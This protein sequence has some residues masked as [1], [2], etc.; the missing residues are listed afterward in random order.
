MIIENAWIDMSSSRSYREELV[1]EERSR[2]WLGGNPTDA[3]AAQNVETLPQ[4][5]S[6][7]ISAAAEEAQKKR[8]HFQLS[9]EDKCKISL[10]KSLLEAFT[11]KEIKF[12]LPLDW[13]DEMQNRLEAISRPVSNS[14][15]LSTPNWGWEYDFYSSYQESEQTTF[16]ASAV[17]KTADGREIN[18]SVSLNLSRSFSSQ[19]ELHIRAGNAQ[20][21]DPLV[22]NFDGSAAALGERS[23]EFDLDCDGELDL[24]SFLKPGSGF[25]A[26][27]LN[28][29]GTIN[30]GSELFGVSNGDGFAHLAQYDE[31]G[32]GWIDENDSVFDRLQIWTKDSNGNDV[33]FA[34][35]QKGIGAIC[36][37]N[38]ATSFAMKNSANELDGQLRSSGIF[39]R[40]NGTAGTI[41]Q[42]DLRV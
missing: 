38:I 27:D 26:L 19:T 3:G 8:F 21:A 33:L 14:I 12:Y 10:I 40:E 30:N 37:A 28:Q 9:E 31:D 1:Q 2:F 25:L 15:N 35:A 17:V 34:L 5:D 11:G 41:Q 16:N 24:I 22:I 42:I 29:D 18:V 6:L 23:F 4:Q 7:E 13:D 20:L 36:L 32:N 39:L